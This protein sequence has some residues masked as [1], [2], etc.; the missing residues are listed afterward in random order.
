[1][2][3]GAVLAVGL[4][5]ACSSAV[6]APTREPSPTPSAH[7]TTSN[8]PTSSTPLPSGVEPLPEP[9]RDH[10]YLE[11]D[12]LTIGAD[13]RTLTLDFVGGRDLRAG[14]PCDRDYTAVAALVD[15][16]LEI[17]IRRVPHITDRPC[18]LMG[19]GRR[20]V[21]RLDE[22]FEGTVWRDR[23]GFVHFLAPPPG[24]VELTGLPAGWKL[25]AQGDLAGSPTGRWERRYSP[26]D[27]DSSI[28][29]VVLYQSFGSPVGVTGGDAGTAARVSGEWAVLYRWPPT[30]G[31]VL[32]WQLGRN[33]LALAANEKTFSV[34]ELI[35]LAE[36]ARLPPE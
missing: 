12:R 14:D 29:T 3:I 2:R 33:E 21:V 17:G 5:A 10:R 19:Y 11:V 24:L 25:R 16:V 4:A 22:P 8:A 28:R 13:R 35:A 31:L 36:S 9:T 15:G 26:D 34:D 23:T 32:V 1:M 6:F 18:D 20:L 30:G 7:P 27:G